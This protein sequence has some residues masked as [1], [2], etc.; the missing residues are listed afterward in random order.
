[1]HGSRIHL[2]GLVAAIPLV[3]GCVSTVDTDVPDLTEDNQTVVSAVTWSEYVMAANRTVSCIAAEGIEVRGPIR[4]RDGTLGFITT[5][6]TDPGLLDQYHTT[7]DRC[8]ARWWTETEERWARQNGPAAGEIDKWEREMLA[9]LGE[10]DGETDLHRY[11]RA[12]PVK[13]DWCIRKH[14]SP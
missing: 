14:P 13:F 7:V 1:M 6:P 3:S 10:M 12:D 9:C 11:S 5:D 4:E 8:F 2:L